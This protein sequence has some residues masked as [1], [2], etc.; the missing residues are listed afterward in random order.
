MKLGATGEPVVWVVVQEQTLLLGVIRK[1]LGSQVSGLC[2]FSAETEGLTR[3]HV[4]DNAK[5]L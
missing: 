2:C 3:Q 5:K 4:M 1:A